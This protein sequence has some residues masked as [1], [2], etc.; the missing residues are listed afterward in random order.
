LCFRVTEA[1][2]A[3]CPG[4]HV[5]ETDDARFDLCA[6]AEAGL[7]TIVERSPGSSIV[8]SRWDANEQ[9]AVHGVEHGVLDL[10]WRDTTFVVVHVTFDP[11]N[12]SRRTWLVAPSRHDAVALFAE[13]CRW[14]TEVR[15]EILVFENG[16]WKKSE[17]LY[18]TIRGATFDTLVL[19]DAVL[20]PLRNDCAGFFESRALY[21]RYSVPWRRGILLTGPPGNGK[22]HTIKALC[23][24]LGT[25]VLY[26]KGL[27]SRHGTD[28]DAIRSVFDRARQVAPCVMVLEDLD[29][30]VDDGNRS[31]F[32]NEMD[33]FAGNDGLLV[34][35]TTNHP[36]RL[37]P[38][39]V[40]RPSRFDRRYAFS[41]PA[42]A[43]RS[44]YLQ[45]WNDR[46]EP[47]VRLS[48]A[49]LSHTAGHTDGFSFAYLKELLV[50]AVITWVRDPRAGA[51]D[52]VMASQVALLRDQVRMPRPADAP[53]G[54]S[55]GVGFIAP[56]GPMSR[57]G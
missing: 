40:Q 17:D 9:T 6:Y 8:T 33:G 45:R 55:A 18:R 29:S 22:T 3:R 5:L 31:Y 43:E 15:G 10:R 44:R 32:L 12:G 7:C 54:A 47:D 51:M 56:A 48:D 28:H 50:S 20:T 14:N 23:N 53:I 4:S 25:P 11:E 26:V 1:L 13:V 36:E 49:G 35:A 52:A 38:A 34:I 42:Y 57:S 16:G 27:R 24:A 41:L 39:I 21:A 37:D 30:I 2:R 19:P 46:A